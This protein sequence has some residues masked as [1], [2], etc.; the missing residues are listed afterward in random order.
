VAEIVNNSFVGNVVM[1]GW[2]LS[3]RSPTCLLRLDSARQFD[4]R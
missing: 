3:R 1:V 4:G 2:A